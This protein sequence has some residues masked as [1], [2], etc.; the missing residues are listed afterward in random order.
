MPVRYHFLLYVFLYGGQ[1]SQ[2]L[3]FRLSVTL[4]Q[5]QSS[6]CGLECLVQIFL[7]KEIACVD[8]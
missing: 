7:S 1:V 8:R 5:I 3:C 2:V 4:V 6:L